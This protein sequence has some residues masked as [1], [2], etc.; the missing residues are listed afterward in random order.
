MRDGGRETEQRLL[1]GEST[2][3][4][5]QQQ[6]QEEQQEEEEEEREDRDKDRREG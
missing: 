1:Y 3:R 4:R 5:E 6:Q 2:R